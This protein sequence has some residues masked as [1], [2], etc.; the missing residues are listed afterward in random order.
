MRRKNHKE[1]PRERYSQRKFR[2]DT[3]V[4]KIHVTLLSIVHVMYNINS[5]TKI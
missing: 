2:L 1:F 4:R 3:S 5:I